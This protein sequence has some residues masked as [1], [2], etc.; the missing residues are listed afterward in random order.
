[1]I[2]FLIGIIVGA[3]AAVSYLRYADRLLTVNQR[4]DLSFLDHI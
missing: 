4:D 1:M 2:L 3:L